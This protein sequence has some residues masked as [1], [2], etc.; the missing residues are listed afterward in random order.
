[1][2]HLKGN[3]MKREIKTRLTQARRKVPDDDSDES[4]TDKNKGEDGKP[5]VSRNL[6]TREQQYDINQYQNN[7]YQFWLH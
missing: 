6:V 3:Q 1:M 5:T 2:E 7:P 4:A